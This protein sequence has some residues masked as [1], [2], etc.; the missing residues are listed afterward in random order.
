MTIPFLDLKAVNARYRSAIEERMA[1]VLDSGWYLQG[2]QNEVFAANFARYCGVPH[3]LGV[4]NGLDALRLII[5]ALGYGP[6][7]EILVPANTYIASILAISDNGCTPVPV[8]PD[9]RSYN[10]DPTL[11]EAHLTPRTRAVLVVHLYGQVADMEPI[12]RIAAQHG[13][14]VIEDAAQAHGALYCGRRVGQLGDA[15]GFSFYPGKNLGAL[16]DAG[17]VTTH[18]AEL[19]ERVKALANYGS[20]RKYHHIYKGL[21]SRLDELQAAVLDV[22]LA[23]LDADNARRREIAAYYRRHIQH[24]EVLLPQV[25]DELGHVWHLFVVRSR[26]RDQLQQHLTAHGVQTLIHY[27]TPPH[28]QGAYREWAERSYP[29][30]EALHRTVLSLPM[31]PVL[32]DAQVRYVAEAVNSWD[33]A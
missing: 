32:T 5:R 17:A 30:T 1:Q 9:A 21:N 27:P 16:G 15:A 25:A 28:R 8:E 11:I 26:R 2:R 3:A 29:I 7:D 13:L 6:G 22:K 12:T 23:Q 31:S 24:P 14:K 10:I 19:M 20:D 18:D 33:P 4:A